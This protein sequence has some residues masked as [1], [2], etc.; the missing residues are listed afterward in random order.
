MSAVSTEELKLAEQLAGAERRA[1]KAEER[2]ASYQDKN[3]TLA[4]SLKKVAGERD[5]LT[6]KL[7]FVEQLETGDIVP[8]KWAQPRRKSSKDQYRAT[9]TLMLSDTH[10][11][12]VVNPAEVDWFNAYNREIAEIRFKRIIESTCRITEEFFTGLQYDGAQLLLGGDMFSGIIHEELKETNET[13]ILASMWHWAGHL[14]AAVERLASVYGNLQ[15][16]CTYGNH[17]RQSRKP[18][19]KCRA[20]DNFEWLLYQMVAKE[21]KGSKNITWQIPEAADCLVKVYNYTTL[22][23]HGDQFHGG[24]GIAGAVSPLLLGTHRKSRRNQ[25]LGHPYDLMAIGHFH[26]FMSLP[27]K[28][29]LVNGAAKGYDEYAFISNF[30]PELAQQAFWLT[31]PEHGVTFSAPILCQK[32]EEEGW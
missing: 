29:L 22:L 8:P 11:D 25:R 9:A 3:R 24:S 23:T 31:T 14:A 27:G 18:R 17:G 21:F 6:D 19:M 15:V 7:G 16:A 32:R 28:G 20:T 4:N 10:W 26:Q 13:T 12:E 30:E 5:R 2:A 1:E